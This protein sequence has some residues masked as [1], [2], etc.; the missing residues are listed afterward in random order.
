MQSCLILKSIGY[1]NLLTV[2]NNEI[3]TC[4]QVPISKYHF[5]ACG[6]ENVEDLKLSQEL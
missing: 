2:S 6:H 4:L 5:N 1:Q 3:V